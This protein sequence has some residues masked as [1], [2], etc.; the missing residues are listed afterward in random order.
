VVTNAHSL[1]NALGDPTRRTIFERVA[2]GPLAVVEIADT[3]DVSRPAVSQHLKVLMEAG[4]VMV[5]PRG[6]R[7][8]YQVDPKGVQAMRDY[9]DG[10]WSSALKAFKQAAEQAEK[11]RKRKR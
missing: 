1:F 4:L 11:E 10:M 6:T 8:L 3:L 5:E 7:R 9:L 2:S